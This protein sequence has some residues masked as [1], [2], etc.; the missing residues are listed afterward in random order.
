MYYYCTSRLSPMP[1][2]VG[3]LAPNKKLENAV[4]LAKDRVKGPETLEISSDGLIYT[5][6]FNGRVVSV[7]LDGNVKRIAVI[8]KDDSLCSNLLNIKYQ[9]TLN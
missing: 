5:G 2:F 4:Y 9:E 7:D 3:N 8:G 1:S 6:L